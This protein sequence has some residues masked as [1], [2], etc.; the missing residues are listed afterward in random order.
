MNDTNPSTDAA[1]AA[2]SARLS[3]RIPAPSGARRG[4]AIAALLAAALAASCSAVFRSSIQGTLIDLEDW[5]DGTTTGIGDA[6]V[7]LYT[8][9][10]ARDEEYAAYVEG[11][12]STLPDG[13]ARTERLYFQ[14]TVSD[15]DGGYEFTGFIW[16]D[17]FP[18]YGKTADRKEVFLVIYHPDYGLWKNPTP[19]YVVSDVTNQLDLI[20]LEDLWNAGSLAGT[21]LDWK[22][23]EPMSGATVSFWVADSWTYDA[24][25]GFADVVY[26]DTASATA[27]TDDD[28]YWSAEI[29]FPMRPDRATHAAH[30]NAPVRV[31]YSATGYRAN[32]P[33][34]GTGL[35]NAGL[36]VSA[37]LDG[38]GKTA[39]AGD[40]A[41][42]YVQATLVNDELATMADATLQR[43]SFSSTV[44]G[45]VI[46]TDPNPDVYLDGVKVTLTGPDGTVYTAYSETQTTGDIEQKGVFNLGTIEWEIGDV[47]AGE[48][49]TGQATIVIK[50]DGA[51]PTPA[52]DIDVLLPDETV[53]LELE[54]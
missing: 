20:K 33:A 14:S 11:D 45:R 9:E 44:R 53:V 41:D 18:A 50:L 54:P 34:D 16:E 5:A 49:D 42:A 6:K 38:D 19:L 52:S 3:A 8:D 32:D 31:T 27:T 30:N 35:S 7:F 51:D 40:Y 15:A 22:D 39:A 37:D 23:G 17:L 1:R 26:D 2:P 29:R 4:L 10:A 28:G 36:V 48:E 12:E 13:S 47:D 24:A 21:V 25:G 43:W 46:D